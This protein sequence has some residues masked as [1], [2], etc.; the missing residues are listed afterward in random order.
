[1]ESLCRI[2]RSQSG[3][4]CFPRLR[5]YRGLFRVRF[6]SVE[7]LPPLTRITVFP[8][9]LDE[10]DLSQYKHLDEQYQDWNHVRDICAHI[11]VAVIHEML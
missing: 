7:L 8:Y 5:I 1:M 4:V 9:D 11:A 10:T 3:S 6:L 2:S